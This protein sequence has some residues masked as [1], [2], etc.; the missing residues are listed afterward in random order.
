MKI[1]KLLK[2]LVPALFFIAVA[3]FS[4]GTLILPKES[5]SEEENRY[6]ADM[7]TLNVKNWFSGN[8]S[9]GLSDWLREHFPLRNG[10]ITLKTA[11]ER[12]A[13][14]DEVNGVYFAD[15]RYFQAPVDYDYENIDRSVEAI[16]S[17]SENYGK[18]VTLLL[19]PTAVQIYSDQLPDYAP[20][21]DQRHMINYVYESLG[22][23]VEEADVYDY[24][25]QERGNY[26]YYRTDHHWTARGA[27]T[28]YS[29]LMREYGFEPV[30]LDRMN[31]EH[32]S[33]SFLGSLWSKVQSD[34]AE[35]DTVDFYTSGG[36][37]VTSVKITKADGNV[38]ERDGVFFREYLEKKDKYLSYLGEN[39]PMIDIETDGGSGSLLVIKDSYANS[40]IPFLTKH[41]SRITAIDLR[42]MMKLSD[43]IDLNQYD[44]VLILYNAETF[45]E[46]RNLAKLG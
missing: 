28:A 42:Y 19:A 12:A 46:D 32:A 21:P 9:A 18:N 41:F 25:Y 36:P 35:P 20:I 34:Y 3:A 17:F 45:A 27:Y 10:W 1:T 7:P 2:A 8:Y 33:H 14:H 44:R 26:I 24:L 15:G 23:S 13:G 22:T 31:I 30:G 11:L 37:Q 6:L 39:V 5:F 38:E 29:A 16:K 43:Y 4:I 40:F